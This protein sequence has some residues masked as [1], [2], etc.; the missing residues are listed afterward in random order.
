MGSVGPQSSAHVL[1]RS[2]VYFYITKNENSRGSWIYIIGDLKHNPKD[3]TAAWSQELFTASYCHL[4]IIW[5]YVVYDNNGNSNCEK[6]IRTKFHKQQI[7]HFRL[8]DE[9]PE[10]HG[11]LYQGVNF[12]TWPGS[13]ITVY[14]KKREKWSLDSV[15]YNSTHMQLGQISMS[16]V[17]F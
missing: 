12:R 4:K 8:K 2:E 11:I 14:K 13:Y 17:M 16:L 10:S 3:S 15:L 1:D 6:K 9:K 7:F 5:L